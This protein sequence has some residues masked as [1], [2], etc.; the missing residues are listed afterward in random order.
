MELPTVDDLKDQG[1]SC[2]EHIPL[3]D[4]NDSTESQ[5][6]LLTLWE[7]KKVVLFSI[8]TSFC[9]ILWGFDMGVNV[10][11]LSL[12]GFKLVFGY[13]YEGELIVGAIWNSLWG[14]MTSLGMV[15]GG[16]TSGFV[17][18]LW[19]RRAAILAGAILSA[20]GVAVEYIAATPSV[21][22]VG[23]IINGI[24]MGIFL[25]INP[26][27]ISEISPLTLRA[28]L[29][30]L[31][32][33]FIIVG[34]MTA[35]GI[36]NTRFGIMDS[37][38][39]KVLFAAQW[40]FPGAIV[41]FLLFLPESPRY[42]VKRGRNEDARKALSRLHSSK[43]DI[44]AALSV[45]QETVT[46][47]LELNNT[48][49]S[50]LACFKGADLR[51]TRIACAM[52]FIQQ[53]TGIALYGQ[54]LYFLTMT[55]FNV[56]LA[57]NLA[58]AGFGAGLI[59][60]IAAWIFMSYFGRRQILLVGTVINFTILTTLGIAGFYSS[61]KSASLYVA[62]V[63]NFIQLIHAPSVSAVS[64]AISGEVS[65]VVL[66]AKT[67]S[68]CTIMNA[69]VTWVFNFITPYLINTDEANL[70]TKSAFM[71][72]GLTLV[73][74]VWVWFEMPEI[75]DLTFDQIDE[76]FALR[77]PTRKF[78]RPVKSNVVVPGSKWAAG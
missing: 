57:A 29:I 61:N 27:Y 64:W 68:L 20:V 54:A 77:T 70:G 52:F 14:A 48:S 44:S 25:S 78:P 11:T 53:F 66:R 51:R 59:G 16:V 55:G 19:G 1:E 75:K 6:L 13:E 47:E 56:N 62:I 42:L 74:M 43:F 46:A 73:S 60:N 72:A 17:A 69:L 5:S 38:A 41:L 45:I 49:V 22:L 50:Y 65:S 23:K 8:C 34:Q 36:G 37:S 7:Y 15:V 10:I 26:A 58:I 35:I 33:F 3:D 2:I 9:A 32:A 63:L 76:A 24:A 28:P 12:P 31:T 21:L 67:Q 4:G 40:A 18:D 30:S 71:W 39:Y